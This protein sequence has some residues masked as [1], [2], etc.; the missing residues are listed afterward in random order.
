MIY[1]CDKCNFYFERVGTIDE[2]PDCGKM[3]IREA[4]EE[5]IDLYLK[6][7]ERLENTDS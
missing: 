5:E 6:R 4:N 1:V 7:K 2:C 3:M